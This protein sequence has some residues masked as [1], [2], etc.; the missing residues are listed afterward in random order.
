MSDIRRPVLLVL[1]ALCMLHVSALNQTEL[2]R[3][4]KPTPRVYYL[5][6]NMDRACVDKDENILG[7]ICVKSYWEHG[8]G[9]MV[10]ES[11]ATWV[12]RCKEIDQN[13][14]KTELSPWVCEKFIDLPEDSK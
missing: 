13:T 4:I 2:R 11:K 14:V 5:C 6:L 12:K 9:C 10:K 8:Y 3:P 7:Y 1:L